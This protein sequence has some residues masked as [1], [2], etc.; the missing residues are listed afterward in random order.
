MMVIKRGLLK[1]TI[2]I[3]QFLVTHWSINL[4]ILWEVL[5]HYSPGQFRSEYGKN[6]VRYK[7]I[8]ANV[9][10][11][12]ILTVIPQIYKV[13]RLGNSSDSWRIRRQP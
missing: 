7:K 3:E 9:V 13:Y 6:A 8:E 1:R 5:N 2:P 11:I 4:M 10:E 12:E